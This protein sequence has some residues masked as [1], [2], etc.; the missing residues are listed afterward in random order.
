MRRRCPILSVAV[1]PRWSPASKKR[2]L[3]SR[4]RP[5]R[6]GT[7]LQFTCV[8]DHDPGPNPGHGPGQS[9]GRNPV[10]GRTAQTAPAHARLG[11]PNAPES[12]SR[13]PGSRRSRNIPG[14]GK[15]E[16]R[17]LARAHIFQT[18]PP[19]RSLLPCPIHPLLPSLHPASSSSSLLRPCRPVFGRPARLPSGLGLS[20]SASPVSRSC[21]DSTVVA[22]KGCAAARK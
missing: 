20:F 6:P 19:E 2:P 11:N 18:R 9:A 14:P 16:H 22:D 17:P 5:R 10:H 8:P 13:W 4:K 12:S 15:A 21:T 1:V 7:R 3:P